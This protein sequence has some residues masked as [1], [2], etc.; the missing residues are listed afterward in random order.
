MMIHIKLLRISEEFLEVLNVARNPP[1]SSPLYHYE[2][3]FASI[4]TFGEIK[5]G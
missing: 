5:I 3:M 2:R 1:A 4:E